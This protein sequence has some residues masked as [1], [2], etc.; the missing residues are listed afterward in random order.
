MAEENTII[1]VSGI[2][3]EVQAGYARR[4]DVLRIGM[5][6]K[7][8]QKTY[9]GHEVLPGVI[10]GFEPFTKLPT[11]VVAYVKSDW[12]STD[13]QF[14]YYNKSTAEKQETELVVA[15]DQEIGKMDRDKIVNS[16]DRAISAKQ[17][18]IT[19]LE[20]KRAYFLTNFAQYWTAVQPPAEPVHAAESPF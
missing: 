18:E 12:S 19:V 16:I 2:K 10:V 20:E 7:V 4:I 8:L 13:I 5:R 9:S 17:A 11:V 15:A 3:M 1:E 6:V 14:L